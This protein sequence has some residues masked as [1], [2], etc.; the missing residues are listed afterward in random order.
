MPKTITSSGP[1]GQAFTSLAHVVGNAG[2]DITQ[3]SLTS[4]T[5]KVFD[6]SSATPDTAVSSPTITIS[7]AVF[8]TLQTD[9]RWSVDDDGYNFRNTIAGSVVA[10]DARRF[11]IEYLFTP[12][13]GDAFTLI[14][15]HQTTLWRSS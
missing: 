2:T 6:E 8:D 1:A 9:A 5:C 14:H 15:F 7:S 10:G 11:R 3:A 4:I 13:S 12:T